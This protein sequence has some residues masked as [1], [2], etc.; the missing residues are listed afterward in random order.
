MASS[1]FYPLS[2]VDIV[3]IDS[4]GFIFSY[5]SVKVGRLG[6]GG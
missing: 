3:A 4:E 2:S 6:G 5:I 1:A